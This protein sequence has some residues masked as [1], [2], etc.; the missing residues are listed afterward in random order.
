MG[1]EVRIKLAE[2]TLPDWSAVAD[3]LRDHRIEVQL[4]MID[5]ALAFPDE[6]PPTDWRELRVAIGGEMITLRRNPGGVDFVVWG[7]AGPDLLRARDWVI[8]AL[9]R[10]TGGVIETESGTYTSREFS[11]Q[12]G[13]PVAPDS[14]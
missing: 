8:W 3:L 6:S 1:L 11:E 5:G 7:N 13:L 9:A 2:A 10:L 12:K 4:R 14:P